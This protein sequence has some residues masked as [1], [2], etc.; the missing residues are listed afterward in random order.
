[1]L[2][3][4]ELPVDGD[5]NQIFWMDLWTARDAPVRRIKVEPELKIDE[6]WVIY[7]MEGR[8]MDAVV[9]GELLVVANDTGAGC[10][11]LCSLL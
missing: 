5:G 7:P 6:D 4:V 9:Q 8:V 1:M 3:R 2:E 11:A 10:V